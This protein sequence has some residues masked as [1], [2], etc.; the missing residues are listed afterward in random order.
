[1][2]L[3]LN[4]IFNL[5]WHLYF[6]SHPFPCSLNE[7]APSGLKGTHRMTYQRLYAS[8]LLIAFDLLVFIIPLFYDLNIFKKQDNFN[9]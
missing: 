8:T 4:G 5:N 9:F 6:V 3:F 1:M 7:K 2:I